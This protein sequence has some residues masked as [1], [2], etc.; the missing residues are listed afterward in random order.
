MPE[1]GTVS[2][3]LNTAPISDMIA[4]LSVLG[5]FI[6]KVS[7]SDANT[8]IVLASITLSSAAWAKTCS[9]A[10]LSGNYGFLGEGT[11][12]KGEPTASLVQSLMQ[13]RVFGFGFFQDGDVGVG[14]FP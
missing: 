7:I 3:G 10:S 11:N 8:M 4:I 12:S 6:G 13:R 5:A 14:V 1:T 9:N 2:P